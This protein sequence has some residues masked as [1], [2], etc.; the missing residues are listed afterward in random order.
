MP[1]VMGCGGQLQTSFNMNW[2]IFSFSSFLFLTVFS[3][4][5]C[6]AVISRFGGVHLVVEG[7][8]SY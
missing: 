1:R 7:R 5:R 6:G 3:V 8:G 2:D 4:S